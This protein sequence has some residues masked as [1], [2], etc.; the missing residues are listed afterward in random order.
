MQIKII[1]IEDPIEQTLFEV[2]ASLE[3][4]TNNEWGTH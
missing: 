4:G 1:G 3:L 2:Y